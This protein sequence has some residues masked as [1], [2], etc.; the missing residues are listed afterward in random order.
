MQVS[1][2]FGSDR[3][4]LAWLNRSKLWHLDTDQ[5]T[6]LRLTSFIAQCATEGGEY[7]ARREVLRMLELMLDRMVQGDL[8]YNPVVTFDTA[9]RRAPPRLLGDF[10]RDML[11]LSIPR[12]RALIYGLEIGYDLELPD[13]VELTWKEAIQ[14]AD[15]PM[16][17]KIVMGLPKHLKL[18]YAFWEW[19]GDTRAMPLVGLQASFD[20]VSGGLGWVDYRNAYR[21]ALRVVPEA[22]AELVALQ[23][24]FAG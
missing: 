7:D 18:P 24:G 23:C 20:E 12:R 22:D 9:S 10:C 1:E 6:T 2:L 14:L 21:G 11:A 8:P 16:A 15:T 19:F 5:I 3:Q 13:I 17:K 4:S